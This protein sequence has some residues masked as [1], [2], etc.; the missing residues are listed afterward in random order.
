MAALE[1]ERANSQISKLHCGNA[2][3]TIMQRL[4]IYLQANKSSPGGA[5][6]ILHAVNRFGLSLAAAKKIDK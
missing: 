6:C 3:K 1:R 4:L 5:F 2:R